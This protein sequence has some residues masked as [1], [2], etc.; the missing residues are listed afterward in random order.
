MLEILIR[1]SFEDIDKKYPP[2]L[3]KIILQ[4]I[5]RLKLIFSSFLPNVY[6]A[7]FHNNTKKSISL[8][9]THNNL[10]KNKQSKSSFLRAEHLIFL[11]FYGGINARISN[12]N[13]ANLSSTKILLITK[14]KSTN[15]QNYLM[16]NAGCG[17]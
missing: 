11:N 9:N 13:L 10:L 16:T 7:S 2:H 17:G 6:F 12:L 14:A 4:T 3:K 15:S 5:N 8:L 1:N